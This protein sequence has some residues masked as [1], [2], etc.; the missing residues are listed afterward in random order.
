M[1]LKNPS[2]SDMTAEI[3]AT[4]EMLVK[5]E[6]TPPFV[7]TRL[8]KH[9]VTSN[10]SPRYIQVV[11]TAFK[12]GVHDGV[13]SGKYG[14][15]AATV[16]AIM[17]DSEA[18]NTVMDAEPTFGKI[19]EPQIKLMHLLRSLEFKSGAD[20]LKEV[21]LKQSGIGISPYHSPSVFN[22]YLPD[23]QRFD[24][25]RKGLRYA[26]FDHVK[27]R[28]RHAWFADICTYCSCYGRICRHRRVGSRDDE[29][30][31]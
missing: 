11:A 31:S 5:H 14:C 21:V 19:R 2:S 4:F 6:N 30:A 20:G 1:S 3:D 17:L 7:A 28:S 26:F 24:E 8:I 25:W 9:L 27:S 16:A 22:Y 15:M 18:R 12:N 10:P 29:R 23:H 13:G